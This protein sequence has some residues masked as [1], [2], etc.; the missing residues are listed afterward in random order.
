MPFQGEEFHP[1]EVR[2]APGS[3]PCSLT[4]TQADTVCTWLLLT[5]VVVL[6]STTKA[7]LCG[8]ASNTAH[9]ETEI[10]LPEENM[11]SFTSLLPMMW[12]GIS[13][14]LILQLAKHQWVTKT[15]SLL[16]KGWFFLLNVCQCFIVLAFEFSSEEV[17]TNYPFTP[18]VLNILI[19]FFDFLSSFTLFIKFPVTAPRYSSYPTPPAPLLTM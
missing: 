15:I 7:Q 6:W 11:F 18:K 5:L 19:F 3:S 8:A 12:S 4:A 9:V 14:A 10:F 13:R 17:S 16:H 1:S 2:A